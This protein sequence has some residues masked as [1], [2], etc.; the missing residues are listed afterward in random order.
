MPRLTAPPEAERKG[1]P[2]APP[3]RPLTAA[4]IST[5]RPVKSSRGILSH[6]RN[7][8]LALNERTRELPRDARREGMRRL[9][10][11]VILTGLVVS[12]PA[13]SWRQSSHADVNAGVCDF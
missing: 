8:S 12:R 11:Q 5:G 13:A 10:Y 4:T 2:G 7:G 6:V 9:F 1:G 3:Q